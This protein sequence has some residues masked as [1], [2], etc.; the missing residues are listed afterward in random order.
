MNVKLG[1]SAPAIQQETLSIQVSERIPVS[2]ITNGSNLAL[3]F[4]LPTDTVPPLIVPPP[5]TVEFGTRTGVVSNIF[6]R[7][8]RDNISGI[9]YNENSNGNDNAI[10][11]NFASNKNLMV[12]MSMRSLSLN[13]RNSLALMIPRIFNLA[14]AIL[15]NAIIP[16]LLRS[17]DIFWCSGFRI[18]AMIGTGRDDCDIGSLYQPPIPSPSDHL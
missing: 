8:S 10:F 15:I 11:R 16:I 18:S 12:I 2:S 7:D 6:S 9:V 3:S 4:I 1:W 17:I 14:K 13:S 5:L